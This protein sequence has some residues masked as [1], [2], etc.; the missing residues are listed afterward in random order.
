MKESSWNDSF[1]LVSLNAAVF[2]KL[3]PKEEYFSQGLYTFDI[4]QNDLTAGYF[5]GMTTDEVKA[6]VPDILNKFSEIVKVKKKN[7]LR[8]RVLGF[9][10]RFHLR[11]TA[12]F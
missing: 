2:K 11:S 3:L 7:R 5:S 10:L 9:F 8:I 12:L 6:A 1:V 4:G